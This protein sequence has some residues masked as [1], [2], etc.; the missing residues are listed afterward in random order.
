[1]ALFIVCGILASAAIW[2]YTC[3]NEL[4][5][6]R[7]GTEQGWSAVEVELKRRLDLISNLVEIVKG[8]ASHERATLES[9]VLKR[10]GDGITAQDASGS[11]Q[12][13]RGSMKT[14]FAVAEAYPDLKAHEQYSELLRELTETENRIAGRRHA[15]NQTVASYQN[16]LTMVPSNMVASFHSFPAKEF[17]DIPDDIAS[18]VPEVKLT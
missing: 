11:E 17:F 18:A 8:Y 5:R 12:M 3:Y 1:M 2:Y 9:I 10:Q 16:L 6:G 15:Y 14:L 4:V 13:V 7:V